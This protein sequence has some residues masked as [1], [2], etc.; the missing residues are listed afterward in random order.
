MQADLLRAKMAFAGQAP[1]C[2]QPG[3]PCQRPVHRPP[4]ISPA[5]CGAQMG[6]YA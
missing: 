4:G 6:P 5:I 1:T 3:R 2:R